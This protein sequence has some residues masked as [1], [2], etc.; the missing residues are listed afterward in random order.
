M[1]GAHTLPTVPAPTIRQMPEAWEATPGPRPAAAKAMMA[2]ARC[3]VEDTK[4]CVQEAELAKRAKLLEESATRLRDLEKER[5][6]LGADDT[7]DARRAADEARRMAATK[8]ERFAA[9]VGAKTLRSPSSA[10][11]GTRSRRRSRHARPRRKR[12][13]PSW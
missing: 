10:R 13:E 1:A 7:L 5:Q 12:R 9:L 4:L 2:A 8:V 3:L 11:R 6:R